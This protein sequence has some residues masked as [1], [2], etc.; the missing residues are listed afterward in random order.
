[1]DSSEIAEEI[2]D[3]AELSQKVQIRGVPTLIING[4]ALPAIDSAS[5]QNAIDKLK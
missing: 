4:E 1:M 3:I 2:A 5:I